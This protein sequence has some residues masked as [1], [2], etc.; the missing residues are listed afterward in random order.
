MAVVVA[1]LADVKGERC[2]P[3]DAEAFYPRSWNNKD[4]HTGEVRFDMIFGERGEKKFGAP[5][6]LARRDDLHSALHCAVPDEFIR[7]GH[8]LTALQRE[9]D[10]VKL[11]SPMTRR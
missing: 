10:G 11:S 1:P 7:R 9:T 2:F 4:A 8:K 6:L 3:G 5:Y